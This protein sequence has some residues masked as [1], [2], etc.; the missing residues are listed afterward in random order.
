MI[1][2]VV[3]ISFRSEN[4]FSLQEL[5][6]VEND[7]H[8]DGQQ[9]VGEE[10]DLGGVSQPVCSVEKW[11]T[12]SKISLCGDAHS[13]EGPT[14]EENVLHWVQEIREEYGI[15]LFLEMS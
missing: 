15:D 11:F 2:N 7:G 13:Y 10:V 1:C 4:K 14:A 5:W 6:D 3:R 8:E 12:D 9:D